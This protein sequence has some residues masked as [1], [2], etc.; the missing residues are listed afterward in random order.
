MNH[1]RMLFSLLPLIQVAC[2]GQC[3]VSMD[4]QKRIVTICQSYAEPNGL[5]INRTDRQQGMAQTV[6]LG[7]EY[8]TY[9]VW[10]NGSLTMSGSKTAIP[11]RIAFNLMTNQ[12]ICRFP[13]D[14]AIHLVA[15]DAFTINDIP[16]VSRVNGKSERAYY[17]VLYAGKTRLLVQYKCTLRPTNREPYALLDQAFDGIYQRQNNLYIQQNN[18]PIQRVRLSRKSLVTVLN[19]LGKLPD[20]HAPKKLTVQELVAAIAYYDGFM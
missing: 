2:Y 11:C 15:P 18:E 10:Q 9:P 16:F 3:T 12:V 6:Y 5:L 7:S 17:R 14:S 13:E 8:L 1:L 4:D 19:A 20:Y